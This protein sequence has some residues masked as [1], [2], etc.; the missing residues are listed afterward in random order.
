MQRG[1]V[2]QQKQALMF[3]RIIAEHA[4]RYIYSKSQDP[5]AHQFHR[6]EVN[7]EIH[8]QEKDYWDNWHKQHID[9]EQ[10]L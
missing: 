6:R 9:A 5:L 3:Q 8:A 4:H 1:T 2:L 7:L 10:N